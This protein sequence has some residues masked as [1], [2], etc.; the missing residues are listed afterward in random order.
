MLKSTHSFQ[1]CNVILTRSCLRL[2]D[3]LGFLSSGRLS[4][5]ARF[6]GVPLPCKTTDVC[7]IRLH[8]H[9]LQQSPP[10]SSSS[11]WA[12]IN[13]EWRVSLN[14]CRPWHTSLPRGILL[15]N[16]D[17][18]NWPTKWLLFPLYRE[19]VS[20]ELYFILRL[21]NNNAFRLAALLK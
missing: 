6:C 21:Q 11:I 18:E 5:P 8:T 12:C 7:C 3:S 20:W 9:T 19:P 4:E 15:Q 14:I 13:C 1:W 17:H 10:F 2:T 16:R